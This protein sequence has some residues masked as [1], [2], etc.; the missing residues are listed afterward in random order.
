[1]G[2]KPWG[3]LLLM[4]LL[5]RTTLP[6]H[7][8]SVLL[9]YGDIFG[10]FTLS[11]PQSHKLQS[12]AFSKCNLIHLMVLLGCRSRFRRSW[13][14]PGTLHVEVLRCCLCSWAKDHTR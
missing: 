14:E 7:I 8:P 11:R 2:R 1:M 6:L 12:T 3:P 4:L 9:C 5:P 13:V 10:I